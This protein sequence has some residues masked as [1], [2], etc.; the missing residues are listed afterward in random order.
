MWVVELET[1]VWISDW[2][3]TLVYASAKLFKSELAARRAMF[4]A[5]KY[6]TFIAPKILLRGVLSVEPMGGVV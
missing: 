3:I 2:G 5:R 6:R 4:R 1:G